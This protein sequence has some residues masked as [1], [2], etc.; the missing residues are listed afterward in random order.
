MFNG[1]WA[2]PCS[3]RTEGFSI[4]MNLITRWKYSLLALLIALPAIAPAGNSEAAGAPAAIQVNPAHV[5]GKLDPAL[6][7]NLGYDPMYSATT[8]D[9]LLPFWKLLRDSGAFRYVRMHNT[10]SDGLAQGTARGGNPSYC[11]CRIYSEDA[12]GNPHYDFH[13]LDE[14][15]DTLLSAGLRPI[16]EA[17]F[18]PDDLASGEPSR[19]YCGGLVNAPKDYHK[20]RDLI[21]HT[22]QHLEERYGA[23]EVRHWYFEIWNEPDLR[24]YFIGGGGFLVKSGPEAGKP[25]YKMYDYFA[26]GAKATD[27]HVKVG[28][29]GLAGSDQLFSAFLKHV[30][31]ETNYATGAVGAPVDF[32]SWHHYSELDGILQ[33]NQARIATVSQFFPPDS[34]PE[35]LQDEWGAPLKGAGMSGPP[36]QIFGSHEAAFFTR[37]VAETLGQPAPRIGLFLRW[38]EPGG[39]PNNGHNPGW[40]AFSVALGNRAVP[41]PVTNAYLLLAKFGGQ[42]VEF[43]SSDRAVGGLAARSSPS[44]VQVAL[45]RDGG[46]ADRPVSVAVT[47]PKGM[48]TV[49]VTEYLI[50][51][52]HAN[53]IKAWESI[54]KMGAPLNI[55][56]GRLAEAARL[57]PVAQPAVTPVANGVAR[58]DLTMQPDSVALLVFGKEPAPAPKFSPHVQR[59]IKAEDAFLDAMQLE[60]SGQSAPAK[61]A[62]EAVATTYADLAWSRHALLRLRTLLK[63]GNKPA[64]MDAVDQRLLKMELDDPVMLD[65]LKERR[66]F[67]L[68]QHKGQEAA[69]LSPRIAEVEARFTRLKTWSSWSKFP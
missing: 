54:K 48:K 8:R 59:V 31:R 44:D 5:V 30:T 62:Y 3:A 43:N 42:Q 50:D 35:L 64:E 4:A 2:E 65:I 45:Y 68:S 49:P 63:A 57:Q 61:Q 20:W 60:T 46:E 28:G 12:A 25:L 15:L 51:A 53:A 39:P 38:G 21:Y 32:V 55:Q 1:S 47:F 56:I 69:A 16:V 14:V 40:R 22:V 33:S 6:W 19:N 66:A 13:H 26:D 27:P 36:E 34:M 11:G 37:M 52:D 7:G 10:F 41:F 23:D 24:T 9:D 29:P 58:F 67:L 17:D 18:M